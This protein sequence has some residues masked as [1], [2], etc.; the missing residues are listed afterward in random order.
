M[1][2]NKTNDVVFFE[3]AHSST[4]QQFELKDSYGGYSSPFAIHEEKSQL[5]ASNFQIHQI[6]LVGFGFWSA[7]EVIDKNPEEDASDIGEASKDTCPSP[8]DRFYWRM[9]HLASHFGLYYYRYYQKTSTSM[10]LDC[11][12]LSCVKHQF[13]L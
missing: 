10:T 5:P 6:P 9:R 8:A 4:R 3:L 13:V 7:T 1:T 11:K 2:K 12:C